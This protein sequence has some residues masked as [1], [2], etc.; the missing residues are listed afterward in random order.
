MTWVGD[1]VGVK[2]KDGEKVRLLVGVKVGVHWVG[3]GVKVQVWPD[4]ST[5]GV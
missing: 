5:Q 1:K 3:V 2:V 4:P